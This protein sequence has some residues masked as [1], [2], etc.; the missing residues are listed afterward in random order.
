[1]VK[2]TAGRTILGNFAPKFAALN[3]D[4]LFGEVWSREEKLSRKLRSI[5]TVSALIGKGCIS[6][7][8][9]EGSQKEWR[10]AGGNGRTSD[11]HCFLCRLA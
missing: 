4:V 3:D 6:C 7:L 8:P 1:M 10:D 5:I 11:A 9:F 2:Q